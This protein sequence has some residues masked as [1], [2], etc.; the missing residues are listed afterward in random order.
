MAIGWRW[1]CAYAW[2]WVLEAWERAC[3]GFRAPSR[4]SPGG[5]ALLAP[6]AMGLGATGYLSLAEEPPAALAIMWMMAALWA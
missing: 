3:A 5:A 6:A 2:A 1:R 4:W